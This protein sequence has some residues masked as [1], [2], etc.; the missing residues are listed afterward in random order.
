MIAVFIAATDQL[1]V[2]RF[3]MGRSVAHE[4]ERRNSL[5]FQ[6]RSRGNTRLSM[7]RHTVG[8]SLDRR[9]RF[10]GFCAVLPRAV[11]TT[12]HR[13]RIGRLLL[14]RLPRFSTGNRLRCRRCVPDTYC[15]TWPEAFVLDR[16]RSLDHIDYR[17]VLDSLAI[18][19]LL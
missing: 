7:L 19:R 1:S 17:S 14:C 3:K 12:I 2:H 5:S 15:C 9:W 11:A 6:R 13:C 10:L 4:K 16:P 8:F 18:L